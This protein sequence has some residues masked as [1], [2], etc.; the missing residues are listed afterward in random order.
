[1][2]KTNGKNLQA[3][4]NQ[5]SLSF[6]SFAEASQGAK[7]FQEAYHQLG[8]AIS[9][10]SQGMQTLSTKLKPGKNEWWPLHIS[11]EGGGFGRFRWFNGDDQFWGECWWDEEK[12]E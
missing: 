6:V 4:I 5:V 3:K 7:R 11:A 1:M 8:L 9:I 10:A 2:I 12:G